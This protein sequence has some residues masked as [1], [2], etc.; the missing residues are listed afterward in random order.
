MSDGR[1]EFEERLY[2]ILETFVDCPVFV[3]IPKVQQEEIVKHIMD[4]LDYF[5]IY[6]DHIGEYPKDG[7]F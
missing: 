6:D 3:A 5:D 4:S 2:M 1:K 7:Y